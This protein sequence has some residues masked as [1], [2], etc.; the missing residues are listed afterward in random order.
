MNYHK[1]TYP[2]L[3]NGL[4]VRITLWVSGCPHHCQGCHNPETWSLQ[5]GKPFTKEIEQ[6][7]FFDWYFHRKVLIYLS[8]PLHTFHPLIHQYI[9]TPEHR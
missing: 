2:D 3:E 9:P 7:L 6:E 1:I 5:S 8:C 4:G